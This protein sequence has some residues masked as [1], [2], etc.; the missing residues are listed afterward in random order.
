MAVV[1]YPRD[2]GRLAMRTTMYPTSTRHW[3][4]YVC[5]ALVESGVMP[6]WEAAK[7][8][9]D[10]LFGEKPNPRLLDTK[11]PYED[12]SRF[13]QILY[14][15]LIEAASRDARLPDSSMLHVFTDISLTGNS[16]VLVVYFP[17]RNQP[18]RLLMLDAAR[19]WDLVFANANE[20]NAWAEDRYRWV[21]SAL[22]SAV[23]SSVQDT[24]EV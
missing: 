14:Q 23:S 5:E 8:L 9:T 19:A 20:F 13:L 3:L 18:H 7:Y 10:H 17:E 11:H 4:V 2:E 6:A 24:V 22:L 21:R 12:T 16:A 15:P 1:T